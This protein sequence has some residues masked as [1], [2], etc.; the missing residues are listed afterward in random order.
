M[1]LMSFFTDISAFLNNFH[2][3]MHYQV[4]SFIM[5][6]KATCHITRQAGINVCASVRFGFN[7]F[8]SW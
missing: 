1:P 6:P 5:K 4:K 8:G 2:Y 3:G 7:G